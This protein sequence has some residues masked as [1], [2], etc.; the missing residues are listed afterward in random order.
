MSDSDPIEVSQS[1]GR[2]RAKGLLRALLGLALFAAVLWWLAPDW[3][4]LA[5]RVELRV[6]WIFVGLAGT[7][8]ASVVTAARWRLLAEAMGGTRLPYIAYFYGLVVTRFIG[9][10]TSTLAM[11]LVGRGLALRSAGSERSLGHAATQVVL[12]RLLDMVLPVLLLAWAVA[13]REGWIAAHLGIGP[14]ASLL[15]VC[16][17]FFAL[18]V[19]LLGPGVR[20]ALRVYLALRLRLDKLRRRQ[21][22]AEAEAEL[23]GPGAPKVDA[24]LSAA[25]ALFSLARFA[26]VVIQFWGIAGAVGLAGL[27]AGGGVE[28]GWLEMSA[29][30]PI[31]QLAG[32]LGLTPGGLGILE[33]GWAGGLGW[34]GLDPVDISLFV[35]AQRV[36]VIAFFGLLSALSWPFAPRAGV[37]RGDAQAPEGAQT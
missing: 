21:V 31:A 33:A 6:G 13:E 25:I 27:H 35:L 23:D 8:V 4:E 12:E 1:P 5:T 37:A 17:L 18:A 16:A 32:M 3:G 9:Q 20:L 22:E 2:R 14:G 28:L 19:P 34:V 29:A 26:T 36:G 30:T 15:A 7:T 11:D 10:F 24:R